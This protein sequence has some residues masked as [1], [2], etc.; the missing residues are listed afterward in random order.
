MVN[1]S[2][3][4]GAISQFI[5]AGVPGARQL[6]TLMQLAPSL[7]VLVIAL[8]RSNFDFRTAATRWQAELEQCLPGDQWLGWEESPPAGSLALS[9]AGKQTFTRLTTNKRE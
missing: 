7:L 1:R 3:V 6:N 2:I 5:T 4:R 8:L 9:A